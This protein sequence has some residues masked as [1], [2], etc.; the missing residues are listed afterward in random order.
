MERK[1]VRIAGAVMDIAPN[2]TMIPLSP[3]VDPLSKPLKLD[4]NECT[5]RPSPAVIAAINDYAVNGPLN[6]YPDGSAGEL[7]ERLSEY[8]S[9]PAGAI[10]CFA[11][12]DMALDCIARTY[13]EP[14]AEAII[15]AP[16]KNEFAASARS[17]GARVIEV[18]H[19]IPFEV[20]VET[21]VGHIGPHTRV[22]YICN[23]NYPT[24]ATFSEA[25]IVFLLAY[26]ERTMVVID[27]PY[28][29]FW[30]RTVA[31][32]VPRFPNLTV[33]RTF[34]KAFGLASLRAGYAISDP[35]NLEYVNRLR[36]CR[37]LSG[38]TQAAAV[39]ALEDCNFMREYV[40]SVNQSRKT[41][42][43]NLAE[44]GYEFQMTPAN[45]LLLKV[46]DVILAQETLG[47]ENIIVGDISDILGLE[48]YIVITVGTTDQTDRLLIALCRA[49]EKLATGLN[50][51]RMSRSVNRVTAG[52]RST[53]SSAR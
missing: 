36:I 14:G 17:T 19:D 28:F 39:A 9:L 11:G 35:E 51:I 20:R 27:E 1:M 7:R 21:I 47:E 50:R 6:W 12:A 16:A 45:F 3:V 40:V 13:L 18:Y 44:I 5:I 52:V 53:V 42:A 23:P 29:E 25:E 2:K 24:G 22:L 26:A 10:C 46:S 32:L 41:L 34:S 4:D 33:V 37:N 15:S 8:V 43:Q 49:A 38:I 31:D 48:N 30:G